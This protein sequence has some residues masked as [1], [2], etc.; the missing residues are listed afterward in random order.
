MKASFVTPAGSELQL[1]TDLPTELAESF[2]KAAAEH[3]GGG[4]DPEGE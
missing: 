3:M 1:E 4:E 2:L